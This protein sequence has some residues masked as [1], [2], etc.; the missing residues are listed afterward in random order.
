MLQNFHP[1]KGSINTVCLNVHFNTRSIEELT[2][3]KEAERLQIELRKT[4][5]QAEE[6]QKQ[7]VLFFSCYVSVC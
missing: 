6:K 3:K 1:L 5:K 2:W 4:V 7:Y